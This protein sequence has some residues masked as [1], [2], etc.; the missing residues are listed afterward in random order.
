[1]TF[2][3]IFTAAIVIHSQLFTSPLGGV[4]I[5]FMN[6][7]VFLSV[8]LYICLLTHLENHMTKFL[9]MLLWPWFGPSVVGDVIF[10]HNGS[11]GISYVFL[12]DKKI[13]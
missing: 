9:Y 13:A 7:F 6:M 11:Y 8:C 12:S 4:W 5:I 3:F 2:I 10:L 1:M